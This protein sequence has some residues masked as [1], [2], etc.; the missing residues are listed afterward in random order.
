[1]SAARGPVEPIAAHREVTRLR[2]Q[3]GAV[4]H[5]ELAGHLTAAIVID[6][7]DRSEAVAHAITKVLVPSA[8]SV[9]ALS[10]FGT[11]PYL[12]D[13]KFA[14][15]RQVRVDSG[16]LNAVLVAEPDE[17][18]SL[19]TDQAL[20]LQPE[21]ARAYLAARYLVGRDEAPFGEGANARLLETPRRDAFTKISE[22]GN[23][24]RS[25]R[26]LEKPGP[27]PTGFVEALR[28]LDDARLDHLVD[29]DGAPLPVSATRKFQLLQRRHDLLRVLDPL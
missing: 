18:H 17:A 2:R 7:A 9:S 13:T 24:H 29:V 11:E 4:L 23:E 3:A 14:S 28:G 10:L 26:F 22:Y 16:L 20:R 8:S 1:M 21:R 5:V 6:D 19:D 12:S 27:L 15:Q 25:W